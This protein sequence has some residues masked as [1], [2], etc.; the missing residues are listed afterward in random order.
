MFAFWGGIDIK[1]PDD[2]TVVTAR[3]AADGRR[4]GQDARAAAG[5]APTSGWSSAASWSWAA[6]SVKNSSGRAT[7]R[8][9]PACIPSWRGPGASAAYIAI[10]LPLGVLLAA[11][12]ALQGV[13]G[14][15]RRGA[16]RGPAVGRVRLPVPVGVVRDGRVAGRSRRRRCASAMTAVVVVVPVERGVAAARARLARRDWV[17]RARWADVPSVVPRRR[18]RRSSVSASCCTC[19]RWR[20]AISRPRSPCR[21]TPSGADSSCRCSRAKPSCARC[22]RRSIRT[23]SSTACSRSAR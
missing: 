3:D 17:V 8:T 14:W 13:F 6:W 2:W 11:L 22:A 12:L 15:T 10:W 18:R 19:S 7:G 9:D 5:A 23:S 20:S 4:R 16:G 1:V 21:A